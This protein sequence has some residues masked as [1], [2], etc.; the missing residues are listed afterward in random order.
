[1]EM[2]KGTRTAIFVLA[3]VLL[4]LALALNMDLQSSSPYNRVVEELRARGY[5]LV[6]SDL[7]FVGSFEGQS[8]QSVL[9]GEELTEAVEASRQGGFH[10]DVEAKG[11]ISVLLLTLEN[12][13]VITIFTRD[14][15]IE[16]CFIQRLGEDRLRPVN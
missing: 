12:Q 6:E 2:N 1:M 14:G 13:D 8:I 4:I 15:G 3:G 11:E 10:S 9:A 7:Y 5:T 16:L